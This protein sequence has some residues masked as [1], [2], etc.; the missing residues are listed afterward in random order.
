MNNKIEDH[1]KTFAFISQTVLVEAFLL[2]IQFFKKGEQ[3]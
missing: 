3:K 1:K 2:Y